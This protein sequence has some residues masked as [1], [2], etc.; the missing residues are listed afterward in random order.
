MLGEVRPFAEEKESRVSERGRGL[1]ALLL[2]SDNPGD[3]LSA[4]PFQAQEG[5]TLLEVNGFCE[6]GHLNSAIAMWKKV[7]PRCREARLTSGE[8]LP[9]GS[10]ILFPINAVSAVLS[11]PLGE[12]LNPTP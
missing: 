7:E 8:M 4:L 12:T 1:P 11:Q 6:S 10:I 3:S 5:V 9:K 2:G